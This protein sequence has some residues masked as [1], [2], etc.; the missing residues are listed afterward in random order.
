MFRVDDVYD[1]AKKI[2]GNC[3]DASLFRYLADA[4]TLIANKGDFEGWKGWLDICTSG[5][6]RCVT[7]PREVL[8]VLA[9]NMGGKPTLGYGTFFNFHLNGI[10]DCKTPCGWSWQDQ[11]AWH[12]TYRDLETPAKV[13]AHL[14]TAEDNNKELIVYGYDSAGKKLR[15]EEGGVW[16]DGYR[17]PTIYGVAVPDTD[18][19]LIARITGIFKEK[20]VGSIQLST[21]DDSATTGVL[22]GVF[23]PDEQVPR[24]RR[25]KLSRACSWVR[26]AYRKTNPSFSS[27]YDHVPLE[28]PL[29]LL[30]A[31]QARKNY[32]MEKLNEAMAYEANAARLELEAQS[33]LEPNTTFNPIQVH[34]GPGSTLVDKEDYDIV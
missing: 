22:L 14:Q 29:A 32:K 6:G 31:V 2:I 23:E 33:V 7:M 11:G 13:V 30:L 15:R 9:V 34:D 3:D 26:I 20:T 24:Y 10:G 5:D 28:S 27:R 8:T 17:V 12:C 16:K 19:P 21:T 25:I 1:E 4:V 18:A